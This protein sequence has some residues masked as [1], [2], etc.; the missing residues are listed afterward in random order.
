MELNKLQR[1]ITREWRDKFQKSIDDFDMPAA[2]KRVG[3]VLAQTE[4]AAMESERDE[5]TKRLKE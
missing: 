3:F 4:L 2:V 1:R 5:L